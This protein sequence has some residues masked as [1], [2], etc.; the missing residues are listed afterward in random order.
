MF[1]QEYYIV[2]P[3]GDIQEIDWPLTAGQLTDL[4]GRPL[5]LPL[6]TLR[7]IV[8]RVYRKQTR[9]AT[10]IEQVYYSLELVPIDELEKFLS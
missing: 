6:T 7:Q 9:T 2:Y 4:N 5:G 1:Q 10:G 3:E 8:Y